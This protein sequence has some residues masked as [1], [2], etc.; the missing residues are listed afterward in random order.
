MQDA[1]SSATGLPS[2]LPP[3]LNP[4]LPWRSPRGGDAL[5]SN[6]GDFPTRSFGGKLKCLMYDLGEGCS[7]W[8]QVDP[9]KQQEVQKERAPRDR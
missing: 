6:L 5:C 7:P 4:G 2:R 9:P 1:R 8:E 3:G